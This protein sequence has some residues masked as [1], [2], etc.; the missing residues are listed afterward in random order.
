MRACMHAR[1]TRQL[2]FFDPL[3]WWT[4][5]YALRLR[6]AFTRTRLFYSRQ[7]SYHHFDEAELKTRMHAV[8]TST[9]TG[10]A[11][12]SQMQF[13]FWHEESSLDVPSRAYSCTALHCTGLTA[14][15]MQYVRIQSS[16]SAWS[17]KVYT[18]DLFFFREEVYFK[19]GTTRLLHIVSNL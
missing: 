17:R 6:S 5:H 15:G 16:D 2:L 12:K 19:L 1:E 14:R 7:K 3:A 18:Q 10:A 11:A 8:R 13:E 9:G 4:E